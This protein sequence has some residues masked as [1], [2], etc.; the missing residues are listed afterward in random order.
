[1]AS[2]GIQLGLVSVVLGDTGGSQLFLESLLFMEK[3]RVILLDHQGEE[4]RNFG[5]VTHAFALGP[6]VATHLV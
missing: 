1:M 6:N 5:A 3:D 2:F 4:E